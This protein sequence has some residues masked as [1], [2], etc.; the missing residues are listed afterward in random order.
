MDWLE[1]VVEQEVVDRHL[2]CNKGNKGNKKQAISDFQF[3]KQFHLANE[4]FGTNIKQL[5]NQATDGQKNLIDNR[6][7]DTLRQSD[8]MVKVK[9]LFHP[10]LY[11]RVVK[12]ERNG[13][14]NTRK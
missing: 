9:F 8:F 4:T 2:M 10:C 3:S 5:V 12:R 11:V 7:S 1:L 14:K 13:E 6:T